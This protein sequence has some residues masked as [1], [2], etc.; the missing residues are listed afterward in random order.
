[1]GPKYK[2]PKPKSNK[3]L[4]PPKPEP[5]H[6]HPYQHPPL[7][8]SIAQLLNLHVG[9]AITDAEADPEPIHVQPTLSRAMFEDL[10]NL[11]V[12]E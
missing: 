1:M 8:P 5:I 10:W 2:M 3:N 7:L 9:G 4:K 11:P 6:V 12:R